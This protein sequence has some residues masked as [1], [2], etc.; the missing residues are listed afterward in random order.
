MLL[1]LSAHSLSCSRQVF[2]LQQG[3]ASAV[4]RTRSQP[5]RH[6]RHA[7]MASQAAA[8]ATEQAVT[9]AQHQQQAA[10]PTAAER[11]RT[12][13][14]LSKSG[15]IS[16]L[17]CRGDEQGFPRGGV[18]EYVLDNTG[19]ALFSL[20][21]LSG[22]TQDLLNNERCSFT[23]TQPGFKDLSQGRLTVTGL[24]RKVPEAESAEA[25]DAY[26]A[27]HPKSFWIDF[28][29]FTM[30]RM[31]PLVVRYNFGFA[32]AGKVGAQEF[33]AAQ[34]DPIAPISQPIA[35]HVNDDH[36]KATLAIVQHFV[37]LDAPITAARV[38]NFDRLGMEV[39]CTDAEGEFACRVPFIRPAETR[40]AVRQM[41]VEM[42][43]D[44]QAP[45]PDAAQ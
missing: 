32:S 5:Q 27:A 11:T 1:R 10:R 36:S 22:H 34:P 25:K 35:T 19:R 3:R 12:L 43:K 6:H 16:T 37:P 24:T 13:C 4:S 30:F 29:D 42:L 41:F 17:A 39:L 21:S 15:V 44:T 26:R 28:G 20:S 40:D 45:A 31:E 7:A 2:R 9:F 18:V 23:V 33:A 14:A 38:L 8:G